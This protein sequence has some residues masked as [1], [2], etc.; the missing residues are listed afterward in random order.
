MNSN[1]FAEP[2]QNYSVA[3]LLLVCEKICVKLMP[4]TS[5]GVYQKI[6]ACLP[7]SK[8]INIISALHQL[9]SMKHNAA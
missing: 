7:S 5:F 4:F 6:S 9:V 8:M 1:T 2:S 3:Y